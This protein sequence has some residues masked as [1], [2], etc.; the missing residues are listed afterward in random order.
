MG[1]SG[2]DEREW[3][4]WEGVDWMGG[5]GLDGREWPA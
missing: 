4:G 2:L 1:G 5:S 3:T